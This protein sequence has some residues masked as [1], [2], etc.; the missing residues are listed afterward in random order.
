MDVELNLAILSFIFDE[1]LKKY[2]HLHLWDAYVS[3]SHVWACNLKEL[4]I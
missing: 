1:S 3:R 2:Q 4:C